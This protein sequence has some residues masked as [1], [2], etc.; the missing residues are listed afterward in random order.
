M[1]KIIYSLLLSCF[2]H[3]L[4]AQKAPLDHSVY[5]DWKSIS[6]STISN[7]GNYI[8]YTVSP[9]EGDGYTELKYH[10]GNLLF[11]ADRGYAASLTEDEKFFILKKAPFFK[12]KRE[13]RI[14]K[15]KSDEMPKDSLVIYAVEKQQFINYGPIENYK[16]AEK[17]KHYLAFLQE[18]EKENPV[19]SVNN[20]TNVDSTEVK[21]PKKPTKERTLHVVHLET[22]KTNRFTDVDEYYISPDEK[23]V[24]FV[25][26]YDKKDSLKNDILHLY[27]VERGESKVISFGKGTYK[28]FTFDDAAAQLVFL[29]DK[30]PEKSLQKDFKVYHY[31]FTTDT[32]TV[33]ID[34][35]QAGIPE[36]WFVSGNGN[37]RF[38]S[39]GERLFL[40]IAP[41]P[42]VKDT[43]LVE[44]EHAVVDIWHWQ[45]DVLMPQQLA[46]L[47]RDRERNYD[48][49]Y[50]FE[51]KALFP[52]ADERVERI[53]YTDSMNNDWA[54]V[55]VLN[56]SK[57]PTQWQLYTY[58]D[59][60]LVSLW[61]NSRKLIREKYVG[62]AAL[63]PEG[64]YVLLFDS[65]QGK[66]SAYDVS[67]QVWRDLTSHLAVPFTDEDHDMPSFAGSYGIAGWEQGDKAVYINDK[68][69]V[70]RF[71]LKKGD[72]K[73]ITAG[74]GRENDLQFRVIRLQE[75]EPRQ[76]AH[77]I[78]R[79]KELLLSS[80]NFKDKRRGLFTL[81]AAKNAI[82]SEL[83]QNTFTYNNIST[84]KLVQRY[85]YTKENFNH[86]PD[87]Y[88]SSDFRD[89]NR[90][91]TIN[92]QQENYNWGT[93]ELVTW[94]TPNGFDGEGIL[95]KP[96]DF[97]P[98][99]KYPII[100]YFYEILT[101]GL[102]RYQAPAPTP[103]RLNIPFFVSNGYLVFCPDIRYEIGYPG[104][105]AEEY[106][107]SGMRFL[108]Q[109]AWVDSTK[110][111][112]Q[113]QSWGGYQVAHLITRTN[114]YAAAWSGAPVVNMT[115]AYG[116]IRWQ[117][118]MSRQFQYEK[119]QS[120]IG[121][122][123]WENLDLYIENSPLF[124][125]DRVQTP[126]AIMANDNDGAV[127]W[128]Q[129]I[130]MFMALRRLGKPSWMLNYNNDAHN[131]MERRNRKDIQIRQQQFFDH[132]LKGKQAP[133]WISSGLS[134]VDKGIL[135]GFD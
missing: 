122:S 92:P 131:L 53:S 112:I 126:V 16:L 123:L 128:Y 129:G 63:S 62:Y 67:K 43:T 34:R 120:R 98:N 71:D 86:S 87:L 57:V 31:D 113:G 56:G 76:R 99:K 52:L 64:N 13:A 132:F 46:N 119:T 74:Y 18:V 94:T 118:G 44:F 101:D 125:M 11:R 68:Y 2:I 115:S 127:P 58:Q 9:Q 1:K 116:G 104:R 41:I 19:D 90:L 78:D 72:A 97:D 111:A 121:Q 10:N 84:D 20:E 7:S 24:V 45:E 23:Y 130:E 35:S 93:A 37:L 95:Y 50:H 59:L 134:A 17:P 48:A 60:Y 3:S 79:Q 12:E 135:W 66:W 40:G 117:T 110:M 26:K 6:S 21:K 32:A 27:D 61:D 89:E 51:R 15:K 103:S 4:Y 114:M 133:K 107:N 106:V 54:L 49:V 81:Q 69:D 73:P 105:S 83:V 39:A 38:D 91:T 65:E 28:G 75:S 14:K 108:A 96:E 82:P 85:I 70:W 55:S 80:F 88:I 36:G 8:Y 22:G 5:D 25:K 124:Y 100:A 42:L 47:K 102:Y 29:A 77:Y 109:N 30:S 33:L